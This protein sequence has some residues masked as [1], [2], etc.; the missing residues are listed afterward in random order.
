MLMLYHYPMYRLPRMLEISVYGVILTLV[1]KYFVQW[2]HIQVII[3]S[4]GSLT[5]I[6]VSF[7]LPTI[8][9]HTSPLPIYICLSPPLYRWSLHMHMQTTHHAPLAC[10]HT[11][12]LCYTS[13]YAYC[14]PLLSF[15]AHVHV[16][17]DPNSNAILICSSFCWSFLASI[18]ILNSHMIC[19]P[20][21]WFRS[22]R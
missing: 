16:L 1:L 4:V 20:R 10:I 19:S 11:L 8:C 7:S 18:H 22:G 21:L 15:Y 2:I 9:V 6:D 13:L 3:P 14:P 17:D 12:Y 5:C